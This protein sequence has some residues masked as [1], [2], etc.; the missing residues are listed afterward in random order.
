MGVGLT[1][2]SVKLTIEG[3]NR[4]S[5]RRCQRPAIRFKK[6]IPVLVELERKF[7]GDNHERR[8]QRGLHRRGASQR[9]NRP[10]ESE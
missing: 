7:L 9:L 6:A 5:L 1:T 8:E 2:H 10:S 3:A 4:I